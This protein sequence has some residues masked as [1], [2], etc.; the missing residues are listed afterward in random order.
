MVYV[1]IMHTNEHV[2]VCIDNAKDK[3]KKRPAMGMSLAKVLKALED[4]T[5]F[6]PTY[7]KV[8]K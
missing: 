1:N 5:E 4:G 3:L 8:Y 7:Q 6:L 2:A